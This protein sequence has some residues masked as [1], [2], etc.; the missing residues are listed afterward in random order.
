MTQQVFEHASFARAEERIQRRR[1]AVLELLT[2]LVQMP[3]VN[4][5][6][7]HYLE[8]AL[9]IMERLRETGLEPRLIEPGVPELLRLGLPPS[10]PRP[11]VLAALE[12]AGFSG[13]PTL[14]FHGHYDVVP[15]ESPDSFELVVAG[16]DARGRGTADMKGGLVA[17]LVALEALRPLKDELRGRVLLSIVPDEET[18]GE[19]GTAYLFRSGVLTP[20]GIGMLMPEPTSGVIWNGNRGALS[21]GLAIH[22][23]MAH[24][25]LQHQGHN[26]FEGMLE[27]G[28]ML[29]DLRTQIEARRFGCE[30]LGLE[31][32]PSTLLIGGVCS[33]GV[34]FN[35]VPEE[36]RF[37]IDRRFHPN[38]PIEQVEQELETLFA[39]FRHKGWRLDVTPL[40]RGAAS[41]TASGTPF[42]QAVSSVIGS[43]TGR[44]PA[45]VLCP[46]ILESRFFLA[47][48]TPGLAYGPGELELSHGNEERV[49]LSRILEV[50]RVYA[51]VAWMLLGPHGSG[52]NVRPR[53]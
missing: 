2:E 50:A 16:D 24:V 31:G 53:G 6:G 45:T 19:A 10:H 43:V 46:G 34:N 14:H 39:D 44:E 12:P 25:A 38:E 5:P 49:S 8:C 28:Q 21:L 52:A 18:G 17:M 22:G 51:R 11:S 41:L 40:Q 1:Q 26:A 3:T 23:K 36:V 32:P 37:S 9:L 30:T 4:P 35:V 29:R 42:V 13:G 27:L 20:Q 7:D 48:G 15:A 47:H 33:G